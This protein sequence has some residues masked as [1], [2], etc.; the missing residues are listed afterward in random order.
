MTMREYFPPHRPSRLRGTARRRP[1]GFAASLTTAA[2]LSAIILGGCAMPQ[3]NQPLESRA[4]SQDYGRQLEQLLTH[5]M[6]EASSA[7]DLKVNVLREETCLRPEN[8]QPQTQTAWVARATGDVAD[9][10][11]ANAALDAAAGYLS[12]QGWEQKNETT[13]ETGDVRK[14][15][16]R[17]GDLG[18]TAAHH[19]LGGTGTVVLSFSSPCLDHPDDHRMV[20]SEQDPEY[21][22][23]SQYYEDGA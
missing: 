19:T 1:P 4:T 21:G 17:N 16:F 3:E 15:Y 13:A 10:D 20:R 12:A 7:V 5:A 18:A 22:K 9:T 6:A 8:E 14:L 11:Q 2:A 23:N